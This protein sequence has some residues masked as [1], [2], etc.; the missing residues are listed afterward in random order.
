MQLKQLYIL[1]FILY[2]Y[3][4]QA[5]HTSIESLRKEYGNVRLDSS[6]C[7]NLYSKIKNSNTNDLLY[8]SYK[9]AIM[10]SMA[11]YTKNKQ[12]KINLFNQG[13]KM[14]EDAITKDTANVETRFLRLTIQTNCPKVLGYHKHIE[15]D[16]TF[17]LN[18]YNNIKDKTLKQMIAAFLIDSKFVTEKEKSSLKN[19]L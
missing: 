15:K 1:I 14:I 16:K 9:G 7:A 12:E 19:N 10:A 18:N 11:S 8:N 5:Q 6:S 3:T 13:K 4:T 17:I 2:S